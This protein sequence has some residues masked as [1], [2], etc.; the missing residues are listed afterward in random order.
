MGLLLLNSSINY[1]HRYM[2]DKAELKAYSCAEK[3][4]LDNYLWKQTG[5]L[6]ESSDP[7]ATT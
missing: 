1:G 6:G 3:I 7:Q 5:N 4:V 2:I